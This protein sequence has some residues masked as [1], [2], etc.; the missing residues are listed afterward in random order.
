MLGKAVEECRSGVAR[1]RSLGKHE[2]L[3]KFVNGDG[4]IT[5]GELRVNDFDKGVGSGDAG[6]R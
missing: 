5:M 6:A 3:R 4:R 1:W 2:I